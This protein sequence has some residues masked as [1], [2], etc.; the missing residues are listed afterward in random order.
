[1]VVVWGTGFIILKPAPPAQSDLLMCAFI[2]REKWTRSALNKPIY[3]CGL[4]ARVT[5]RV[6]Y[7]QQKAM[8]KS[9]SELKVGSH[10]PPERA[11]PKSVVLQ[12]VLASGPLERAARLRVNRAPARAGRFGL[13]STNGKSGLY[14][15]IFFIDCRSSDFSMCIYS[16]Y[17]FTSPTFLWN[18]ITTR[19]T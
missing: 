12:F 5:S 16:T 6:Q 11:A 10:D 19:L 3:I 15:Y 13:I 8:L 18:N 1:M 17:I 14:I 2:W 9:A 7:P 4:T